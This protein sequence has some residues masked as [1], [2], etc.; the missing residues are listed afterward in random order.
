ML[1]DA[2]GLNSDT[3][4]GKGGARKDRTDHRHHA[5]D[6]V[7]VGLIDRSFLQRVQ[8]AARRSE[9]E[10]RRRFAD[11]GEPWPGFVAEVGAAA[12][13]IVVSHKPDHGWQDALHNDTAYGPIVGAQRDEPN[14]VVR[15]PIETLADK[16]AEAADAVRDAPLREKLRAALAIQDKAARKAALA[17]IEHPAGVPVRRVRMVERLD[18]TVAIADR[19]TGKPYKVMKRDG[20]HRAEVWRMPDGRLKLWVVSTFDAAQ[21]AVARRLGRRVPDLRPHPAAKL[22]MRLHK[23]DMVALGEGD[24]FRVMRVVKFSEGNI[25]LAGHQEGGNLKARDASKDDDFRYYYLSAKRL[26]EDNARP[27]SVDPAG[28]VRDPGPIL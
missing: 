17:A 27:V 7:V 5:I 4:L 8:T 16:G 3:V 10:G 2:L 19:R 23:N 14:V 15:R 18:S 6:A 25:T 21:E 1:R 22:L 12:R 28:V 11:L 20:N 13:A 26:R 24:A 9:E